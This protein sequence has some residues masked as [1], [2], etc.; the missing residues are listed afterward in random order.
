M[1]PF[2]SVYLNTWRLLAATAVF[3]F[4]FASIFNQDPFD[5]GHPAVVVFFVISGFVIAY[6]TSN[7][8]KGYKQYSIDRISRLYSV[9]VPALLITFAIN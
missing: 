8:S 7:K 9:I 6:T 2:F 1:N 5:I 4:H 3:I